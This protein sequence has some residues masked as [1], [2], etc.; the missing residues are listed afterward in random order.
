MKNYIKSL[1]GQQPSEDSASW[2]TENSIFRFITSN[3]DE[4][5]CLRQEADML[6]DEQTEANKLRFASGL[7]DTMFG[8]SESED[9]KKLVQELFFPLKRIA[10]NGD[11]RSDAE[12]YELAADSGSVMGVID[13]LLEAIYREGLPIEPYLFRYA[14]DLATRSDKRNA[15]KLGIA[16]LG[17]CQK[18]AALDVI[19]LLGLHDEFT[20]YAT[21]AIINLARNPDDLLW[22][23]AKKVKGWGRIQVVWRLAHENLKAPIKDWLVR[24]GYRNEIMYQYLAYPCALYGEL[25]LKLAEQKIDE[26]LYLS[27][28]DILNALLDENS[29]AETIYEYV[30]AA[31]VV[32][33]LI[34]HTNLHGADIRIFNLLHKMKE[35]LEKLQDD[36]GQQGDNG[37]NEDIIS[38]CLIDIV[39]LQNSRDW[40]QLAL[41]ALK[42][43]DNTLYWEG[44]EAAPRLGIDLWESYWN[45]L[46][47]N[48]VDSS[49]W[50]NIY[51]YGKVDNPERIIDFAVN[52]LPLEEISTG[53]KDNLS[54]GKEYHKHLSLEYA[55]AF[56]KDYP[57]KGEK[58]LLA[59]LRSPAT[60]IRNKAILVLQKWKRVNWSQE[61]E[62]EVLFLSE[63]EPNADTR[64]EFQLL[65][66]D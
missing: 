28:T 22:D 4:A 38:N 26:E 2:R 61:I 54:Y 53:A 7:T 56:L 21:V 62:Q 57:G 20:V 17:V 9:A 45:R 47:R 46:Q 52:N 40:R 64:K 8:P 42:S 49:T 37:W 13:E 58:L 25:H 15:V 6:P 24:E 39:G 33:D 50:L 27:A 48:P 59:A 41:E 30:H 10:E 23:L 18:S 34:R 14:R 1:L 55:V 44:T 66:A 51:N 19:K 43:D 35:F 31:Q 60:A 12:F 3:L 5:G 32:Q 29:P 63:H 11:S 36:L 16:L 65:L